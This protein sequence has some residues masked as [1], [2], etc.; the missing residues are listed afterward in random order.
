MHAGGLISYWNAELRM[1]Q[2]PRSVVHQ[3]CAARQRDSDWAVATSGA[4]SHPDILDCSCTT[5]GAGA[6]VA[7]VSAIPG[8]RSIGRRSS[9]ESIFISISIG[10]SLQQDTTATTGTNNHHCH[11]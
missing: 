7:P 4:V 6:S 1:V 8:F 9:V 11:Q 2:I 5:T 10:V 3:A